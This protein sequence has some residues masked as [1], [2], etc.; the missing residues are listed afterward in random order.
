MLIIIILLA[1][2]ACFNFRERLLDI[3]FSG[4]RPADD[5]LFRSLRLLL[6]AANVVTAMAI[7][8]IWFFAWFYMRE[9]LVWAVIDTGFLAAPVICLNLLLFF[10]DY[11]VVEKTLA[12]ARS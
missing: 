8:L 2:L 3:A 6:K 4:K 7:A 12:G 5:R 10:R 1:A 9:Q 11:M